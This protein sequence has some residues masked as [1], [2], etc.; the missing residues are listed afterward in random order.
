M[1]FFE[2]NIIL[3]VVIAGAIIAGAVC[4]IFWKSISSLVNRILTSELDALSKNDEQ[5]ND[6]DVE[7]PK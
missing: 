1:E 4:I 3:T 5:E 2:N 6:S 7:K